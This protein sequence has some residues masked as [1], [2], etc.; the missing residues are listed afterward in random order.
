MSVLENTVIIY[1]LNDLARAFNLSLGKFT[2]KHCLTN[3][4][5]NGLLVDLTKMFSKQE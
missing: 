3:D 2:A 1:K 5:E 4:I